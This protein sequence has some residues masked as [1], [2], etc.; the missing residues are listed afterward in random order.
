MLDRKRTYVNGDRSFGEPFG[1]HITERTHFG[2]T[3]ASTNYGGSQNQQSHQGGCHVV[4]ISGNFN[5]A[6]SS[7]QGE[8]HGIAS[9]RI[10]IHIFF[11]LYKIPPVSQPNI[12]HQ[13]VS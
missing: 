1:F 2:S 5:F 4:F 6:R 9:T 10:G 13:G 12:F 7:K 8:F 3:E 11:L